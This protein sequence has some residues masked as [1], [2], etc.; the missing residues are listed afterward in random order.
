MTLK[1]YGELY[2]TNPDKIVPGLTDDLLFWTPS[3]GLQK[4]R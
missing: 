3:S 4:G 2:I 1:E